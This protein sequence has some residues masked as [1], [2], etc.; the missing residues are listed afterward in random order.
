MAMLKIVDDEILLKKFALREAVNAENHI[1]ENFNIEMINSS[2]GLSFEKHGSVIFLWKS[3]F[4][5]HRSLMIMI[6]SWLIRK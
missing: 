5:F 3:T 1:K 6:G 2:F 4:V